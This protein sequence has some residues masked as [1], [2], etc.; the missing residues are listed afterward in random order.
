MA[1]LYAF[2]PVSG[3][4]PISFGL[5]TLAGQKGYHRY[6]GVYVIDT[7]ALINFAFEHIRNNYPTNPGSHIAAHCA[8]SFTQWVRRTYGKGYLPFFHISADPNAP[9]DD[10]IRVCFIMRE[11]TTRKKD[12]QIKEHERDKVIVSRLRAIKENALDVERNVKFVTVEN[13]WS[14]MK[15]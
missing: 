11:C 1:S 5:S 3:T 13:P 4:T 12:I 8:N 9:L 15:G 6:F 14:A 10:H 7:Q 2:P